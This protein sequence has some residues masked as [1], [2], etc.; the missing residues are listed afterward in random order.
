MKLK[1][2]QKAEK[3]T[4]RLTPDQKVKLEKVAVRQGKKAS[5]MVRD[6]VLL[7]IARQEAA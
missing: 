4:F 6:L 7:E 2:A 5:E 1:V 3:F